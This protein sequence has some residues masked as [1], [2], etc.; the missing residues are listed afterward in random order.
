MKDESRLWKTCLRRGSL[1]FSAIDPDHCKQHR[2]TCNST[3]RLSSVTTARRL[4]GATAARRLSSAMGPTQGGE[5]LKSKG[6]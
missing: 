3:Q 1:D 5:S 2:V 4:N 6:L